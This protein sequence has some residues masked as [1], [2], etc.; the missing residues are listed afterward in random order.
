MA[1]VVDTKKETKPQPAELTLQDRCDR[2]GA[3]ALTRITLP[4]PTAAMFKTLTPYTQKIH[5]R[6]SYDMLLCGHHTTKY[7]MALVASSGQFQHKDRAFLTP[8]RSKGSD[9]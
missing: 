1:T 6:K 3:E 7:E 5:D 4:V 8:D 2:C 9:H